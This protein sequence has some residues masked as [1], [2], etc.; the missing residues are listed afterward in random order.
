MAMNE[1]TLEIPGDKAASE[2]AR[3]AIAPFPEDSLRRRRD[4]TSG[5]NSRISGSGC[6]GGISLEKDRLD[7]PALIQ[8]LKGD[9]FRE[10]LI[11]RRVYQSSCSRFDAI[12][13]YSGL[14][15]AG[16]VSLW[17]GLT[18]NIVDDEYCQDLFYWEFIPKSQSGTM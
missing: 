6:F 10:D 18:D 9:P 12:T 17:G 16:N 15:S 11:E 4:E 5:D 2:R 3:R 1:K 7:C 13:G 14:M 8:E